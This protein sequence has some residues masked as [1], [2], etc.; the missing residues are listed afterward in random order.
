MLAKL[1]SPKQHQIQGLDG[2]LVVSV[3]PFNSDNQS[4]NSAYV[5]SFCYVKLFESDEQ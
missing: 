2:G 3:F 5:D 1:S 4:L